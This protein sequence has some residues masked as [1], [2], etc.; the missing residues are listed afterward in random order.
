M[1]EKVCQLNP[2]KNL[3]HAALVA[4]CEMAIAKSFPETR[5][6]A[7]VFKPVALKGEPIVFAT[8]TSREI[9]GYYARKEFTGD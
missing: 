6:P 3:N 7:K 8:E 9:A 2:M 1:A 4:R 5:K